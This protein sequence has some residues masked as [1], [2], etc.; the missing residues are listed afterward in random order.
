MKLIGIQRVDYINKNGYHVLG[1]KLHTS[2]PAIWNDCIGELT[3]A[4]FVSDPVFADCDH[5][6]VGDEISI[7]YNKFGKVTAVSVIG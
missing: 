1:Y 2:T 5:L 6:A 4:V 3:E 7:A